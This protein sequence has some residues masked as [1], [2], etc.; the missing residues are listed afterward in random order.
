MGSVAG[1][2]SYTA[3]GYLGAAIIGSS[4]T[5]SFKDVILAAEAEVLEAFM[6]INGNMAKR[7]IA[8]GPLPQNSGA[9]DLSVPVGADI[10]LFNTLIIRL[11]GSETTVATASVP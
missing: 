11:V 1:T 7:T 9:F 2:D 6:T 10:S 4:I 3:S 8:L 5:L